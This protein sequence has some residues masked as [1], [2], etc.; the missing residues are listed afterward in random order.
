VVCGASYGI[1]SEVAFE[2]ARSGARLVLAAR[3]Q[4]LLEEVR[5]RASGV[6]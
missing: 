2:L 1:G 4:V 5:N 6:S 3:S